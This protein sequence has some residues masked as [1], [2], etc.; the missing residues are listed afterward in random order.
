M[1]EACFISQVTKWSVFNYEKEEKPYYDLENKQHQK[2]N[3]KIFPRSNSDNLAMMRQKSKT[4]ENIQTK[5]VKVN[6][7]TNKINFPNKDPENTK[8]PDKL[9]DPKKED[10]KPFNFQEFLIKSQIRDYQRNVIRFNS[11]N[12]SEKSVKMKSPLDGKTPSLNQEDKKNLEGSTK[13]NVGKG[14]APKYE[15][16]KLSSINSN[17]SKSSIASKL[18]I[19]EQFAN[20]LPKEFINAN[21]DKEKF[22]D[23]VMNQRKSSQNEPTKTSMLIDLLQSNNKKKLKYAGVKK[24]FYL[25][26]KQTVFEEKAEDSKSKGNSSSHFEAVFKK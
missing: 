8:E 6:I 24:S 11:N 22:L 3:S 2:K 1:K 12:S 17:S 15:L 7:V 14:D 21:D 23:V 18:A 16:L 5:I 9:E 19:K 25:F 10:D 20:H 4:F 26:K 13:K